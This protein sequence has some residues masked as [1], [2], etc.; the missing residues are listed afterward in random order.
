MAQTAQG[1]ACE[2]SLDQFLFVCSPPVLVAGGKIIVCNASV[3]NLID[4]LYT[5]CMIRVG[6]VRF[7][8]SN[9]RR[10]HVVPQV[11]CTYDLGQ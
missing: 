10:D 7:D 5:G 2:A 1:R 3:Q 8:C 11:T 4:F 6:M 9:C